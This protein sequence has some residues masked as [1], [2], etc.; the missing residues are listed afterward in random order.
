MTTGVGVCRVV[1]QVHAIQFIETLCIP[2]I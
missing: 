1:V 2:S